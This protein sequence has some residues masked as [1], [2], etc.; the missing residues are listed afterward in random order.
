MSED[1]NKPDRRVQ[2]VE[3][4]VQLLKGLALKAGVCTNDLDTS[5][6]NLRAKLETL[7]S[8][9]IRPQES[10]SGLTWAQEHKDPTLNA[11]IAI[12]RKIPNEQ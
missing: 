4:A 10:L 6:T 11:L 12:V 5:L 8:T 3:E 7:I 2:T 1:Y 9:Q